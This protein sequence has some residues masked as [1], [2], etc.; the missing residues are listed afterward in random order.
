MEIG[1]NLS[2]AS[3]Y[4]DEVTHND[5]FSLSIYPRHAEG[6]YW[7]GLSGKMGD[8]RPLP[9][10]YV[11]VKTHCGSRCV[12]C[13][14][15]QY[16]QTL[17]EYTDA[18]R[19][20]TAR[21]APDRRK[22]NYLYPVDRVKKVIH[23]IRN[24]FH[25]FVARFHLESKNYEK[26]GEKEWTKKHPSA[27]EGF[28]QWC[29]D[30]DNGYKDDEYQTFE[31]DM[32]KQVRLSPCH[33]EVFK[34]IQWHNMAFALTEK[35]SIP[36]MVLWYED[37]DDKYEE[38]FDALFSF[39]EFPRVQPTREFSARH[40]Y[41][42]YYDHLDRRRMRLLAEKISTKATWAHVGKYFSKD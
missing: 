16:V 36:S 39:M 25:N 5:D 32:L 42:T 23:L 19:N 17:Q 8:I 35:Y 31:Y 30:L 11:L 14:P 1:S 6:P 12:K 28:R 13:P 4:G 40:D 3:N 24:P 26:K 38:T 22:V 10:K 15:S 37:F 41:D 34:Y 33:G 29:A 7:E 2:T 21:E 27:P 9:S 20:S 18:C